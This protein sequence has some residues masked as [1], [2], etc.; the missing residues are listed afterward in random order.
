MLTK[1]ETM[2]RMETKGGMETMGR[3]AMMISMTIDL[4]PLLT[5]V[6]EMRFRVREGLAVSF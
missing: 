2:E 3:V 6:T 5:K 1:T 4:L